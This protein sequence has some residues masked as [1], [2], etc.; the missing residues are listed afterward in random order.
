[1]VRQEYS[2]AKIMVLER[3]ANYQE[4]LALPVIEFEESWLQG[5]R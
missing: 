1:M 3:A 5:H 2:F 4:L